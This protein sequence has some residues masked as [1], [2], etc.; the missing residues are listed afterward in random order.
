VV[1]SDPRTFAASWAAER[2]VAR[3]PRRLLPVAALSAFLAVAIAGAALALAASPAHTGRAAVPSTLIARNASPTDASV[4]S[5]W[6]KDPLPAGS[7]SDDD[8][9]TV[10]IVLLL[11]GAGGVVSGA[12]VWLSMARRPSL[13]L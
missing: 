13:R 12:A 8:A 5:V 9:R 3:G 11:V 2:G 6:I 1:G 7:A 10:G 4:V